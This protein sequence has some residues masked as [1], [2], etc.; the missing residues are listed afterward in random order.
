LGVKDVQKFNYVLL[1]KWKWRLGVEEE[2]T[3][4]DVIESKYEN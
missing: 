4:R 3:W 2:D 1:A